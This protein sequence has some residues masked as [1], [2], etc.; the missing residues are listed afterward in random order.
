MVRAVPKAEHMALPR[1]S[2][3][4]YLTIHFQDHVFIMVSP[5]IFINMGMLATLGVDISL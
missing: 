1:V 5:C 2:V 4:L 3:N